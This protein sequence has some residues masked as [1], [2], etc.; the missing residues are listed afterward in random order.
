MLR[1]NEDEEHGG[2]S[3]KCQPADMNR[4]DKDTFQKIFYL[5]ID[6]LISRV[7]S[8]AHRQTG[9]RVR[10]TVDCNLSLTTRTPALRNCKEKT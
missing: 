2:H 1:N 7:L 8:E 10:I 9:K 3:G 4:S 6:S 5:L